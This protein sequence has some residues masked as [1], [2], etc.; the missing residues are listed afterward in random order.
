MASCLTVVNISHLEN[1]NFPFPYD[2]DDRYLEH[3]KKNKTF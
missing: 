3:S 2:Y 1:T